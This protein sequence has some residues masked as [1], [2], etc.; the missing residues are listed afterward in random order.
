VRGQVGWSGG[1][2]D[3]GS[4]TGQRRHGSSVGTNGV[5]LGATSACGGVCSKL[6]DSRG[7]LRQ[8]EAAPTTC[9]GSAVQDGEAC[10]NLP[11]SQWRWGSSPVSLGA[12]SL[13]RVARQDGLAAEAL[14]A[15]SPRRWPRREAPGHLVETPSGLRRFAAQGRHRGAAGLPQVTTP[16][17]CFDG[18]REPHAHKQRG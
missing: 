12:A 3:G 9:S 1:G 18:T 4:G 11:A 14:V 16:N 7:L 13:I 2:R 10:Q 6:R 17:H 5:R 8:S 15:G